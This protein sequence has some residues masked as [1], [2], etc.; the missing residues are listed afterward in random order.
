MYARTHTADKKQALYK[1]FA[2]YIHTMPLKELIESV[3]RAMLDAK[4]RHLVIY[5]VAC[6]YCLARAERLDGSCFRTLRLS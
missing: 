1:L 3:E 2:A 5:S 6:N 4:L